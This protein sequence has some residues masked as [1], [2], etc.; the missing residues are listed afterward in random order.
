M[1]STR[2]LLSLIS[3]V[4]FVASMGTPVFAQQSRA[5]QGCINAINK[6]AAKVGKAQGKENA[7]CVKA[8][9]KDAIA[10][11]CPS[12]DLKTKVGAKISKALTDETTRCMAEAPSFAHTSAGTA[13]TAYQQAELDLLT[14]LFGG[15]D[16]NGRVSLN[17]GVGACQRA[18]SK[19][20]EKVAA[21]ASQGFVKCKKAALKGPAVTV[22][23][24]QA[25]VGDDSKG[26]VA[27]EATKLGADITSR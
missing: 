21:A 13:V 15:T 6:D 27:A 11:N 10:S 4:A 16:L 18:V 25:C 7:A 14:D 19:D 26:K 3:V 5:Q 23:Q 9:T 1:V 17:T 12:A 2:R 8:A 22:A 24:I 20:L